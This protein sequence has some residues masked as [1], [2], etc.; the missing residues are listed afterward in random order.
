VNE[1]LGVD[2]LHEAALY[3]IPVG[4]ADGP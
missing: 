4:H 3:V 1:L 2:G